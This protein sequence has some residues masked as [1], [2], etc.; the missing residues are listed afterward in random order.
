MKKKLQDKLTLHRETVRVL[1]GVE[2][3]A[4]IGGQTGTICSNPTDTCDT[5]F[6]P[7]CRHACTT[8]VNC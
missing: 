5:C 7:S 3:G 6:G 1:S 2:S 4:V 8:G